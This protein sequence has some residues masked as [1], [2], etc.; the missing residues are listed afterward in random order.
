MLGHASITLTVDTYG[1]W[2]PMGNKAAVDRL[3]EVVVEPAGGKLVADAPAGTAKASEVVDGNGDPP[4]TR[5]M[6]PEI[7]RLSL[8]CFLGFFTVPRSHTH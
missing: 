7:K 3:D 1:K 4:W 8:Y 2:L 6:N 5:T